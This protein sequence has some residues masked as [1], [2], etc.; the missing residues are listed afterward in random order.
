MTSIP[1]L[2]AHASSQSDSANSDKFRVIQDKV[3]FVELVVSWS[4]KHDS[5][6]KLEQTLLK[7]YNFIICSNQLLKISCTWYLYL[8]CISRPSVNLSDE[9]LSNYP[10]TSTLSCAYTRIFILMLSNPRIIQYQHHNYVNKF[11]ILPLLLVIFQS[12]P[13]FSVDLTHK[14]LIFPFVQQDR[15]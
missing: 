15:T 1:F 14:F 12:S 6:N 11:I 4:S 9:Y 7:K 5:F 13:L 8:L 2:A 3:L 10:T